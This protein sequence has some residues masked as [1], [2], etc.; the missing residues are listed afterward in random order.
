MS[1]SGFTTGEETTGSMS[2]TMSTTSMSTSSASASTSMSTT[3]GPTTDETDPS[4]SSTTMEVTESS[5]TEDPSTTT[6]PMETSSSSTDPMETSS[7]STDP[8]TTTGPIGT[9][10]DDIVDDGLVC[11]GE[12]TEFE[13]G[14]DPSDVE[15]GNFDLDTSVDVVTTSSTGNDVSVLLGDGTG[16][17]AAATAYVIGGMRPVQIAAAD[18]NIDGFTDLV[19]ANTDSDDV[20]ILL[21]VGDGSLATSV[22][23]PV[24]DA[25]A[26]LDLAN[27]NGDAALDLIVANSGDGNYTSGL[28]DGLG[29]FT[30]DAG[31][32]WVTGAVAGANGVVVGS[33]N[34]GNLDAWFC[35]GGAYGA[36]PG[37]GN[38]SFDDTIVIAAMTGSDLRNANRGDVNADTDMDVVAV[39]RDDDVAYFFLGGMTASF[40]ATDFDA[41]LEPSEA[42]IA[43]VT[44]E[45]DPDV[46]VASEA[47]GIV[48]VFA[49][50]GAGSFADGVELTVPDAPVAVAAADLDGD[51]VADIITA[52]ASGDI[53]VLLSDP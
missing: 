26:D 5:T 14:A 28:N 45:G 53:A 47:G 27:L 4:S 33:I 36:S 20:S 50:N 49:G 6:D 39:D 3:D 11:F 51:D 16:S 48:T 30:L 10:S 9:C 21:A 15:V 18:L 25:P 32:P 2:G 52:H 43:D 23:L 42:I 31:A 8:T 24:G 12:F 7:S 19:T 44:G 1:E 40:S 38:G 13:T 35:N 41:G 29:T 17:F 37:N 46:I 34:G 22:E